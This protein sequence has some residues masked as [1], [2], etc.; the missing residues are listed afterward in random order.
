MDGRLTPLQFPVAAPPRP[1]ETLAAASGVWW[2]RMQLPFVLDH[3]NLWLLEDGPGWTIVDTGYVKCRLGRHLVK[4]QSS[5]G[6]N[7][8]AAV[9]GWCP[10]YAV[11]AS[12]RVSDPGQ[13]WPVA[14]RREAVEPRAEACPRPR[15]LLYKVNSVA[16][17]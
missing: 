8:A 3:I 2:L 13:H 12:D 6:F 15:V 11:V 5:I 14:H 1:G 7:A 4:Q 16:E 17:E 9:R 10:L